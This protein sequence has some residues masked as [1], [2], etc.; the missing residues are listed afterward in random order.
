MAAFDPPH[1]KLVPLKWNKMAQTLLSSLLTFICVE[2][3]FC[4]QCRS[5]VT[6]LLSPPPCF[7]PPEGYQPSKYL[8]ARFVVPL[9]SWLL[10]MVFLLVVAIP[11]CFS[12]LRP[13]FF[14][15][16]GKF[17]RRT[18]SRTRMAV[19]IA[20]EPSVQLGVLVHPLP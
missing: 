12:P 17:Q 2:V 14:F 5:E 4:R 8:G 3:E 9:F 19:D 6:F 20:V 13:S 18:P 7:S 1:N 16:P 11:R 10:Q 15:S